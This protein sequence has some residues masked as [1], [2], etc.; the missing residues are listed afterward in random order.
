MSDQTSPVEPTP[1]GTSPDTGGPV[2]R[3]ECKG[4]SPRRRGLL[5]LGAA[6]L[7]GL[8]GFGI[9][10]A[11]SGHFGHWGHMRG[12]GFAMSESLDP[13]TAIQMADAGLGHMLTEIDGTPEQKTKIQEIANGAL[14][15][16]LPL[17]DTVRSN[18]DKLV[19]ALKA[20]KIDRPAIEALRA[21]QLAL[22]ETAFKRGAQAL[23]DAADVLTPAQRTTLIDRWQT[24]H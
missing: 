22:A 14:K 16:L 9:G 13:A 7:T 4:R 11:T 23:E 24:W 15:D 8:V 2:S 20:E 6:L 1:A 19:A 17:R 10:H 21:G 12:A 18:R 5:L 3:S